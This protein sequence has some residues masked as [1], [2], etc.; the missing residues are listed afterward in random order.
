MDINCSINYKLSIRWFLAGFI[1]G[2]NYTRLVFNVFQRLIEVQGEDS[3]GRS[4]LGET[5]QG[6]TTEEAHGLPA[7]SEVLHGN[8]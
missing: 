5:L 8:Q 1:N 6:G 7:E 2:F 4:V 3:R